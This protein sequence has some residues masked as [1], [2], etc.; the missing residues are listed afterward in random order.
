MECVKNMPDF[1]AMAV[2]FMNDSNPI[3]SENSYFNSSDGLHYC[4]KCHTPREV[5]ETFPDGRTVKHNRACDCEM[6]LQKAEELEKERLRRE[7]HIDILRYEAF[8]SCKGSDNDKNMRNWTF[9]NDKGYQPVIMQKARN[10]VENF[11]EFRK[12][13]S[14]IL[15]YGTVGTGKS[16]IAACIANALIDHEIPVLMTD[17]ATIRNTVWN[18]KNKQEYYE[19]LNK[20]S[21]LIIDDL[22]TQASSDYMYE[23]EFNV[24]NMRINAGLPIIITTNYDSDAIFRYGKK[25]KSADKKSDE[26]SDEERN[27][28]PLTEQEHRILS[29]LK[30]RCIPVEVLGEDLRQVSN[31]ADLADLFRLLG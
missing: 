24:I 7:N 26:E 5:I 1:L 25:V 18:A 22:G 27:K 2:K 15:F 28:K 20:Y 19:S 4:R 23:I 10:Y 14:G 29:R 3:T 21:L 8:P 9:E 13:G 30:G 31:M 16:Y 17:F 11:S 12:K 6:A